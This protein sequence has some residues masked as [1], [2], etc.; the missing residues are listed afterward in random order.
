MLAVS[1]KYTHHTIQAPLHRVIQERP[2]ITIPSVG[3]PRPVPH[4]QPSELHATPQDSVGSVV[5][6]VGPHCRVPPTPVP[7]A[8]CI[9]FHLRIHFRCSGPVPLGGAAH[10][11]QRYAPKR[12]DCRW[13]TS[14]GVTPP[15]SRDVGV[16]AAREQEADEIA[17]GGIGL[18]CMMRMHTGNARRAKEYRD[19]DGDE[20]ENEDETTGAPL[21]STTVERSI[22]KRRSAF[23]SIRSWPLPRRLAM[24]AHQ[25]SRWAAATLSRV[26]F[27][28]SGG[29][30]SIGY[31]RNISKRW[32][33][34]SVGVF[35]T[36]V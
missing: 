22:P 25:W 16:G 18:F 4:K 32:T 11:A 28:W 3:G 23:C 12:V 36:Y 14:S 30:T 9:R 27:W 10:V 29:L 8:R 26:R 7:G 31:A 21:G 24:L 2:S 15:A 17:V 20:D 19:D 35:A 1:S 34:T 33:C 6:F 13:A 5:P